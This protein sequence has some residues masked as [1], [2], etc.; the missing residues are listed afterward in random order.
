MILLT[1]Y[2][3]SSQWTS[4]TLIYKEVGLHWIQVVNKVAYNINFIAELN[5]TAI[6]RKISQ[7]NRTGQQ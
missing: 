7:Q 4:T 2:I 1:N 5:R 6:V 3:H